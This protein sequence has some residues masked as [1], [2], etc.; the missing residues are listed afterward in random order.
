MRVSA[1]GF[2]FDDR[3]DVLREAAAS[4]AMT[5]NHP[6]GIKGAQ[7][8][9]L[10][11]FL[12]RQTASKEAIRH[13]IGKTFNYDLER[14]IESIRPGYSFDVSCQGSV[15]EAIIAFLDSTS[16]EDAVRNAVSLGGDSDTL[17]CIAGGVA[18]AWYG[19]VPADVQQQVTRLLPQELLD[20]LQ[21]FRARFTSS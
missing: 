11:I 17:A 21:R 9:A 2:A 7:A 10:A 4:A 6:E 20:I 1:I 16:W 5:H 15:P 8:T 12:G 13:E 3:E 14:S 18:E 19:E